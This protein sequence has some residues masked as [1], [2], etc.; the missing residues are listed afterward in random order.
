MKNGKIWNIE[1]KGYETYVYKIWD[2]FL[3]ENL[4][5]KSWSIKNKFLL[6]IIFIF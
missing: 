2:F 5:N 4:F 3:I 1:G 6:L